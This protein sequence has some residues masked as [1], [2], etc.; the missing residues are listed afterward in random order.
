MALRGVT[1]AVLAVSFLTV[2][3]AANADAQDSEAAGESARGAVELVLDSSGS[4]SAD[5]ASGQTRIEAAREALQSLIGE[6]PA[7]APVGLRVYGDAQTK[8]AKKASCD[9]TE[10]VQ[11][12]APLDPDSLSSQVDDFDPGGSTPIG[13]ALKDAASDLPEDGEQVIVLVSDGL[14]TCAP[15]DPCDVAKDLASRGIDLRVQAIGFNVDPKARAELKCI[16]DATGGLYRDAGDADSL[17]DS[18]RAATLRALRDYKSAGV[19]VDGGLTQVDAA[20]I[21]EGQYLDEIRPDEARWYSIELPEGGGVVASGTVVPA[22]PRI[23]PGVAS[24]GGK[25][26]G[27]LYESESGGTTTAPED[28]TAPEVES[29]AP[30]DEL[31]SVQQI[32]LLRDLASGQPV[33][34]LTST[35]GIAQADGRLYFT[36]SLENF[37]DALPD[38]TYPL[39]LLIDRVGTP[40]ADAEP[41]ATE[42][43][44]SESDDGPSAG[45]VAG[46]AIVAALLGFG[47]AV[48]MRRRAAQ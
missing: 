35:G 19:P 1:S 48:A 33:S 12:V 36:V 14:D 39:E 5:D 11:D 15:P 27:A 2:T 17:A 20:P 4:M 40:V 23:E 26:T 47:A 6:L 41:V 46:I 45:L 16:A 44:E 8:A 3:F 38:E 22:G 43:S 28:A 42:P 9:K 18:L 7:G 32:D 37:N 30:G 25:F 31:D 21:D 29:G 10:L 34:V 13:L 24:L